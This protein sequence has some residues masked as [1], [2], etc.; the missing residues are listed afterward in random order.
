M[1]RAP[2]YLVVAVDGKA[3]ALPVGQVIEVGDLGDVMPVPTRQPAM[4]GVTQLR[5]RMLPVVHLGALMRSGAAP[6][7]RGHTQV[8][9]RIGDRR[10]AFEVD[11]ADAVI[12]EVA[13]PLPRGERTAWATGV[14]RRAGAMVP[15]LDVEALCDKI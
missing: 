14:T 7:E 12:R 4:R 8:V 11:E 1:K 6:P 5:G 15:I 13:L 3:F 9:T 10:V 2:G